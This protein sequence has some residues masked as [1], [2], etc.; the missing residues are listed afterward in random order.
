MKS[1]VATAPGAPLEECE[2]ENPIPQ[3]REVLV[4]T[5][6]SG[7][8]HTDLHSHAG[9]YDLGSMGFFS[10]TGRGLKYPSVWGHEIVGEV[11]SVGPEVT[12]TK[13]GDIRLVFPWIGCGECVRCQNSESNLC[14]QSNA[15]G[16][17]RWGGFATHCL[18]PDEDYLIDI[19]GLDPSWAATL[20]CSG[21][22][23][24]AAV[25]K[26]LPAEDGD[27]VVVIGAGG[28]GLNAVAILSAMTKVRIAVV[29]VSDERLEIAKSLGAHQVVNSTK[30]SEGDTLSDVLGGPIH[31]AIDFVNNGATFSLAFDTLDKAG[32]LVPVG[33]FGGETTIPNAM[34]PLRAMSILGSYVGNL[35]ELRELVEFVKVNELPKLPINEREL[36][37]EAVSTA[38]DELENGRVSG[39][40][41]LTGV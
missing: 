23:S 7:V 20:A 1:F 34:M 19:E 39:R 3:G 9:G 30:L 31:A 18:V 13:V 38:M 17:F 40:I 22:T 25:K 6:R 32:T 41:I 4:R 16:V 14:R 29:D 11:V 5:I 8:C 36:S 27:T 10:M 12:E 28:V 24:Y 21:V 33:L 37:L 26:V 2:V 15:I 35:T